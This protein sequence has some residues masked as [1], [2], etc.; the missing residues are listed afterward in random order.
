MATQLT[1]IVN[2]TS[3]PV[4]VKFYVGVG[5]DRRGDTLVVPP[6][7]LQDGNYPPE[8]LVGSHFK[9]LSTGPTKTL[10]TRTRVVA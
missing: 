1:D 9:S 3:T 2:M 6:G 8:V 7:G 10:K 4:R 5:E